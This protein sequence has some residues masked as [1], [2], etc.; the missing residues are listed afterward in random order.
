MGRVLTLAELRSEVASRRVAGERIVLTNGIFDLLHLGHITYLQQARALG[1][2]LVV[3]LNSDDSARRLKGPRRPI[4]PAE[5]RA[6]AV[7]ALGCVEYAMIFEESTAER[8]V[9]TLQPAVYV[10]GGD[11]AGSSNGAAHT[12]SGDGLRAAILDEGL[13]ERLPEARIV[14][15]FGGTVALLPYLPDHS[16]TRLIERIVALYGAPASGSESR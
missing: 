2:A 13:G 15:Q 10:K 4:V 14:E 1:D 6:Y 3:A 16:T 11:Y 7:A 12:F 5:E 9:A 8:V